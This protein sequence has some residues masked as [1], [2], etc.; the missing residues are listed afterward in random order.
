MSIKRPICVLVSALGGQGGG[1]MADWLT[2]AARL[3][4]FPAQATSIP[5]VAQRTGATTY[6]FEVYPDRATLN[7]P[8]FSIYPAS[9][10]IDLQVSFEPTEA[11]R[12]LTSGFIGPETTLITANARIFS[13]AEK[14]HPGNG[15]IPLPPVLH[16]LEACAGNFALVDIAA[17]ARRVK[18]HPNAVMFGVMAASEIL[19]FSVQ[20]CRDAVEG[21]AVAVEA[22]LAGFD[23]G[24]QL[25]SLSIK[26]ASL[27]IQKFVGAP[28]DFDGRVAALPLPVRQMA[29]HAIAQLYDYQDKAYAALFINRLINIIEVDTS[30]ED[31]RLSG[32]VARR[33]GAWM[34]F[35]DVIRV[36]QLKTRPG[37]FSRI[38]RELNIG[39]DIPLI[40]HDYLKPGREELWG[41][42]PKMFA[43]SLARQH[44]GGVALKIKTSGP[45][46]FAFMR[47]LASL[48]HWRPH[49]A[50]FER[51]Q[52]MIS[53]WLEAIVET[54]DQDYDL[55]CD[56]A[57]LAVWA[58]GYG[59]TRNRGF[60]K[61]AEIFSNRQKGSLID[62]KAVRASLSAAYSDPC[63]EVA[64]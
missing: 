5:G 54:A 26:D 3:A 42:F 59:E 1:V 56:I 24:T 40:V 2:A 34:S 46:G 22:N 6:Y 61:L 37:R 19:P 17:A 8:V 32:I 55:A 23:I 48:K 49:T 35:E 4:G 7:R 41:M 16:A 18:C 31:Y 12:A 52:Q 43:K 60:K 13:T 58:R 10:A 51:E 53:R 63:K 64:S 47:L 9:G 50:R 62:R 57:D 14:I 33:L 45:V 29:G 11:A 39:E 28:D 25:S 36:G 27:P 44:G 38:R 30:E 15:A 20:I 21:S